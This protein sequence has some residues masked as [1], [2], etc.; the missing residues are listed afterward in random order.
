MWCVVGCKKSNVKPMLKV[1]IAK[2][3]KV[4]IISSL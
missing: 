2:L 4:R 3:L 1:K